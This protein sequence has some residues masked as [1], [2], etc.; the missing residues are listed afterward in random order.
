MRQPKGRDEQ[1]KARRQYYYEGQLAHDRGD[2]KVLANP[3]DIN[4][5]NFRTAS[6]WWTKGWEDSHNTGCIIHPRRSG[7]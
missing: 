2:D 1:R 3:Y 7:K 4:D 5:P 6:M